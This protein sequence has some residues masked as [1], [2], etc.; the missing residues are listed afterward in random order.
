MSHKCDY[1]KYDVLYSYPLQFR[2]N[3]VEIC[4]SGWSSIQQTYIESATILSEA[5]FLLK[6][7]LSTSLPEKYT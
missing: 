3:R 2:E 6:M 7:L 5:F 4:I 1:R